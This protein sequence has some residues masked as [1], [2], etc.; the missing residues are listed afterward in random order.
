M[1]FTIG[2][3]SGLRI[4]QNLIGTKGSE[5]DAVQMV[6]LTR[7]PFVEFWMSSRKCGVARS[8]NAEN[9]L[10]FERSVNFLSYFKK[11]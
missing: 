11:K 8:G 3:A 6:L 7:G 9:S 5:M 10:K 4:P 1:Q 2:A